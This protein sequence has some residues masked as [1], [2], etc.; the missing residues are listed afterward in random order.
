MPYLRRLSRGER[1][2]KSTTVQ[3][4]HD[5]IAFSRY[6]KRNHLLHRHGPALSV[7]SRK[8]RFVELG[9]DGGQIAV[10]VSLF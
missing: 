3:A 1:L 6:G 9:V 2:I 7:S 10:Y 5:S 8:R 4:D